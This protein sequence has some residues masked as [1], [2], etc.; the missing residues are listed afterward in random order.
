MTAFLQWFVEFMNG[1]TWGDI[2]WTALFVTPVIVLI[3]ELGHAIPAA[4][5]S[6]DDVEVHV[7]VPPVP[8]KFDGLTT[9]NPERCTPIAIAVIALAGPAV[10]FLTAAVAWKLLGTVEEG[11]AMYTALGSALVGSFVG[12]IVC[13]VPMRISETGDGMALESDGLLAL[14]ALRVAL[15]R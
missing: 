1:L 5:L 7:Q 12:A 8:W 10:S 4:I 13:L 15:A 2:A 11:T 14:K 9:F 3:H 6:R